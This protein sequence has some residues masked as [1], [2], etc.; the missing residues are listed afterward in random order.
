M[1]ADGMP[2]RV[3]QFLRDYVSKKTNPGTRVAMETTYEQFI[4]WCHEN[5]ITLFSEV[6]KDQINKWFDHA[7]KSLKVSTLKMRRAQLAAA[8]SKVEKRTEGYISPWTK[9]KVDGKTEKKRRGSWTPEQFDRL[10]AACR[11]WLA[12]VLMLGVYTGLRINALINVEKKHVDRSSVEFEGGFGDI[13]VPPELDKGGKGYVVP[14]HAKLHDFLARVELERPGEHILV[15]Q[16]G[17]PFAGGSSTAKAIKTACE[18]AGLDNPDSPNHHMRRTFG[19]WA[20][21]GHLTG[22]PVPVY[23]ISKWFGHASVKMTE[24]YLDIEAIESRRFMIGDGQ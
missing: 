12:D 3:D 4:S 21:I 1:H 8:W 22:K 16:G 6:T 14:I 18:R 17:K 11:P 23:V 19:R 9:A 10:L 13:V 15:G 2:G 5:E 24:H 20:N 7:S